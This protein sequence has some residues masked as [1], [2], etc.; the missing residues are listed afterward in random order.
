MRIEKNGT[1]YF[2]FDE[3]AQEVY[4]LKPAT[5]QVQNAGKRKD[6]QQKFEKFNICKSCGQ[7][8]SYVGGNVVCCQNPTLNPMQIVEAI[9]LHMPE[10]A[11]DF[12]RVRR[13]SLYDRQKALFK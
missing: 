11:P 2:G 13:L 8:M 10:A 1:R 6:M 5:K 7:T 12:A 3:V 9:R 4:G